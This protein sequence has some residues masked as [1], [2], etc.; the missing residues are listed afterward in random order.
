MVLA[1]TN[2]SNR[3]EV[4]P[5]IVLERIAMGGGAMEMFL[6]P[7]KSSLEQLIDSFSPGSIV[8]FYFDDR[9]RGEINSIARPDIERFQK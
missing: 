5:A 4:R 8:S 3:L 6:C 1:G 7:S 9:F 2:L